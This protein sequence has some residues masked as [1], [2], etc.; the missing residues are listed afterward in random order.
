ME[1]AMIWPFKKRETR[2]QSFT[3]MLMDARAEMLARGDVSELSATVQGCLSLWEQGLS[4][5]QPSNPLLTPSVLALTARSLG[6]KGESLWVIDDDRLIPVSQFDL[7]TKGSTPRAYRVT[8][9]DVGGGTSTTVLADEVLHFRIG[10]NPSSPWR[11]TPPIKRASLTAGLLNAVEDSLSEVYSNAPIG[12]QIV[13]MPETSPG[14]NDKLAASFRGKRGRVLLRESTVVS[15]AGGPVP[16]TDWKPSDL[17]PNLKDSMLVDVL[18]EA[19]SAI[20]NAYGVLPALLSSQATG[21][22]VREAQRHLAQWTLTPIAVVMASECASKLGETTIE[23][24]AP[25]HAFDAGGRARALSGVI[26]SLAMAKEANLTD[27]QMKA[28][29]AFAGVDPD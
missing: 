26:A 11:G 27:E 1:V 24:S 17:T 14:D 3:T 12:S 8:I 23:V 20:L 5:A 6:L 29:L 7:T 15:A 19:K 2:S 4:I 28:A 25:L 10:C 9:P 13:A 22:V 18:R 21:P 16:A